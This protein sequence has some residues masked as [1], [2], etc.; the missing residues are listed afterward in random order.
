MP[1]KQ[2]AAT[3]Q[4]SQAAALAAALE[5]ASPTASDLVDD[6]QQLRQQA[7]VSAYDQEIR[8]GPSPVLNPS[9]EATIA[10]QFKELALQLNYQQQRQNSQLFHLVE[11]LTEKVDA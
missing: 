1:G 9:F 6:V 5:S 4:R 8:A 11:K 2:S 3:R 10:D 7:L